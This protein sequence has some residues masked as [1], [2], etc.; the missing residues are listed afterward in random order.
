MGETTT[1]KGAY[2][3]KDLGNLSSDEL[4]K[5][6]NIKKKKL[7]IKIPDRQLKEIQ[8]AQSHKT[9]M[10]LETYDYTKR[11]IKDAFRQ[12]KQRAGSERGERMLRQLGVT[13]EGIQSFHNMHLTFNPTQTGN[14]YYP[15]TNTISMNPHLFD[16]INPVL[17]YSKS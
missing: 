6:F 15:G 1:P 8:K 7:K 13:D 17:C 5:M 11:T 10:D 9:A 4:V 2:T 12:L 3:N 14:L 16:N